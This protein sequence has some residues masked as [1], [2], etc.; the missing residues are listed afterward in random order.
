MVLVMGLCNSL[1]YNARIG[2]ENTYDS[3]VNLH[4]L[5]V[6]KYELATETHC[7][8]TQELAM[9]ILTTCVNSYPRIARPD[10]ISTSNA[11]NQSEIL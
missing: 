5:V 6:Q 1:L 2:Y 4:N 10:G 11:K 7:F 8:I 3:G 9:K